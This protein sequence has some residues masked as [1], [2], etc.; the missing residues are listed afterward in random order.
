[1][2]FI[3]ILF[4]ITCAIAPI[5]LFAQNK[6][7]SSPKIKIILLGTF[8]FGETTD[9]NK[10]SFPDLFGT[11]R[12]SELDQLTTKLAAQQPDAVFVETRSQSAALLDS[13]FQAYRQGQLRDT[14]W[15][16]N[17]IVQ[18]GFRTALKTARKAVPIGIDHRQ[19]LPYESMKKYEVDHQYDN[20]PPFFDLP[21]PF[22]K[23]EIK[24][25]EQVTLQ[26]Y[27]IQ[28]NDKRARQRSM[29]DYLH[30]ALMYGK[31]SDYTGVEFATS[32][33]NRNLKV[34]TNILRELKPSDKYILVIMGSGHTSLLHE[35]FA[36]HPM[37]EI[38]EVSSI[39]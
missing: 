28:L 27:L 13:L 29:Y 25:L 17:E 35:L 12:Q 38:V 21:Y 11:K 16:R 36:D 23:S 32:W 37:F 6:K 10:I 20:N 3:R 5:S 9:R 14:S 7:L 26:Q 24:K 4:I 39:L 31:G 2:Q 1:M 22:D 34:M 18:I 19:E 30:Y 15:L 33:Y 8:H